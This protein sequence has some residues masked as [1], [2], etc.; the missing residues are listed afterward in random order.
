VSKKPT[1]G[2][3]IPIPPP[4]FGEEGENTDQKS[5]TTRANGNPFFP[6]QTFLN[7]RQIL[8]VAAA[9]QSS[10]VA[11]DERHAEQLS[12]N[13]SFGRTCCAVARCLTSR[14]K[15][16]S[17]RRQRDAKPN[18]RPAPAA[19]AKPAAVVEVEDEDDMDDLAARFAALKR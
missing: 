19:K 15:N 17:W 9:A 12:G 1:G 13:V 6:P 5:T 7:H 11:T 3:T 8:V 4:D 2:D 16:A 18:T 14:Q 10:C